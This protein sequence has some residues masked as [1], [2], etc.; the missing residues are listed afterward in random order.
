MY[1]QDMLLSISRIEEYTGELTFEAF[2]EDYRTIDAVIRNFDILGEASR[3]IPDAIKSA[4]P[5]VPWTE[6]YL[7]RNRVSHAYLGVDIEILWDV[8]RN[9]PPQNKLLLRRVLDSEL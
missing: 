6:M 2:S 9:H 3:N 7:L 4:H 8:I 1:V 5:D